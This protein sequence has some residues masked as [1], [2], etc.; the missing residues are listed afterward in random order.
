MFE[1]IIIPL[2]GSHFAETAIEPALSLAAKFDSEITLVQVIEPIDYMFTDLAVHSAEL[3][4]DLRRSS[5]DEALA[6]LSKWKGELQQQGYTVHA[7]ILRG[8]HVAPALLDMLAEIDVDLVVMS[9]HGRTG[10]RRWV[11]GSVAERVLRHA[12]GPILLIHPEA[13]SD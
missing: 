11:M 2:D 13:E 1:H 7:R 6:Y 8:D 3:L 10:L 5:Y 4:D 12:D 9:T